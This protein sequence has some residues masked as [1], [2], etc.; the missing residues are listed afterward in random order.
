MFLTNPV[1]T[2]QMRMAMLVSLGMIA[3]IATVLGFQHIGGYV[4]CE[5]CYLQREPYYYI[6]MPAAFVAFGF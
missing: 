5:L 3:V 1:G 4:P 6:A 2:N